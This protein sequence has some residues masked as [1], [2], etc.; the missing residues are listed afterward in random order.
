MLPFALSSVGRFFKF[1]TLLVVL[2]IAGAYT[3]NK[4][5]EITGNQL[6]LRYM[7]ETAGT[8]AGTK[9]RNLNTVTSYRLEI[10]RTD[11]E[12]FKDNW[13]WG[14]GIGMSKDMR[15][16]YGF[17]PITSHTEYTRLLSEQG[18]GGL[19][20]CLILIGFP[21]WWVYKQKKY[22]WRAVCAS[23]FTVALLTCLH[24]AMRTNTT[25]VCFVLAAMP[26]IYKKAI[27]SPSE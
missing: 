26:V 20:V 24:S 18:V 25:I 5:N 22:Y 2:C 14:V 21:V 6:M 15:P 3:F 10:A 17:N 9:E 7:G 19:L 12:M 1:T 23:L 27:P 16:R 11:F 4:V 13:V 8:L